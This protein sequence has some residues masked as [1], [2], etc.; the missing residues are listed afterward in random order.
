MM[1]VPHMEEVIRRSFEAIKGKGP[2]D[3][4]LPLSFTLRVVGL[5]LVDMMI[6]PSYLSVI[7]G[8][9]STSSGLDN[10]TVTAGFREWVT[11]RT[12]R[13]HR[14]RLVLGAGVFTETAAVLMARARVAK[15]EVGAKLAQYL[16]AEVLVARADD[17]AA[18]C[19]ASMTPEIA[20]LAVV[21]TSVCE[22]ME[23]RIAAEAGTG[24]EEEAAGAGAAAMGED[25]SCRSGGSPIVPESE[26][27]GTEA[28]PG[29]AA[30]IC[31]EEGEEEKWK[32]GGET[33][34]KGAYGEGV[35]VWKEENEQGLEQH[36]E[37]EKVVS[38]PAFDDAVEGEFAQE[39][40]LVM[41]SHVQGRAVRGRCRG[42]DEA[43]EDKV[44]L[45]L[46][47]LG[48]L[49]HM[50]VDGFASLKTDQVR[51]VAGNNS[52]HRA[53]PRFKQ[54][55]WLLAGAV[56]VEFHLRPLVCCVP[57][58]ETLGDLPVVS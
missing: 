7:L 13:P 49:Q 31:R 1:D 52:L 48:Q 26:E 58:A 12:A 29:V 44:S 23:A 34:G 4:S 47:R 2:N 21:L 37:A 45:I 53:S 56:S 24:T 32:E 6:Y 16:R 41:K 25:S 57:L 27:V 33:E 5:W 43:S 20:G 22:I 51:A 8:V 46:T 39:S 28:S 54:Q 35:G 18:P 30:S 40:A 36:K 15:L 50:V 42:G 10:S 19:A 14:R 11:D 17:V 3:R 38:A 9:L 55:Q